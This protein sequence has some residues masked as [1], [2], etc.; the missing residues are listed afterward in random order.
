MRSN[1]AMIFEKRGNKFKDMSQAVDGRC[2]NNP[3]LV[4]FLY[5]IEATAILL[6]QLP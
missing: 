2:T 4:N 6:M 3:W 5:L 1:D